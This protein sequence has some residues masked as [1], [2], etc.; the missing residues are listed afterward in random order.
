MRHICFKKNFALLCGFGFKVCTKFYNNPP[1]PKKCVA[2]VAKSLPEKMTGLR[3]LANLI[4]IVKTTYFLLFYAHNFFGRNC[5]ATVSSIRFEININSAFM[6][7]ML[8]YVKFN[9]FY[10]VYC[11]LTF[12]LT[13]KPN[14]DETTKIVNL[15]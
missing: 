8:N 15:L 13:L 9:F 11:I 6:I 4:K 10:K 5:F 2:K 12:F 14:A 7:P 1:P 3:T